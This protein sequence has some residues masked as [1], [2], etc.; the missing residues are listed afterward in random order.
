MDGRLSPARTRKEAPRSPSPHHYVASGQLHLVPNEEWYLTK[1][2]LDVEGTLAR[3]TTRLQEAR[4]QGWAQLRICGIPCKAGSESEWLAC[5]QYEQQIH[6]LVTDMDLLALCAYR[7]GRI[8][9]RVMDGLLHTHHT[10]LS[11]HH[12]G[13]EYRPTTS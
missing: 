10:A 6:R 11:R 8:D 12:D 13:W 7:P 4:G 3:A 1:D 9:D 5:L 2:V